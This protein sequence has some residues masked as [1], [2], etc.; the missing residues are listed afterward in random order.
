MRH[1]GGV[2]DEG[3][4]AVGLEPEVLGEEVDELGIL[5]YG[6]WRELEGRVLPFLQ[7]A[8]ELEHRRATRDG[9]ATGTE[10][11]RLI[12]PLPR[13]DIAE[14]TREA[15]PE[16]L[17]HLLVHL[18]IATARGYEQVGRVGGRPSCRCEVEVPP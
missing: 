3:A 18:G 16:L 13:G 12:E 7:E 6:G 11:G 10:G 15:Q 5:S 9:V 2:R 14:E 4:E 8:D 1:Q 17:L